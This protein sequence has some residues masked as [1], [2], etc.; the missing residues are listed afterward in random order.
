MV[1]VG[2]SGQVEL[3]ATRKASGS[4]PSKKGS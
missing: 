3:V 2:G 4:E 1:V